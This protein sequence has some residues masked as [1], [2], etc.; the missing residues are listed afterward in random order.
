MKN[1]NTF[2][3]IKRGD[4]LLTACLLA[5]GILAI[6]LVAVLRPEGELV[7]VEQDGK[8]IAVYPLDTDTR[9]TID[10]NGDGGDFNVLVI[11]DGVAFIESAD[12]RDKICVGHKPI[13][14]DG[15]TVVC[16]P[17]RLV[18]RIVSSEEEVA[19]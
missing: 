16:L 10:E 17:H 18:V 8:C 12:C 13:S 7:S 6:I 1:K 14:K 3:K 5:V 4:I 19:K 15:E 9:V 2:T 11:K